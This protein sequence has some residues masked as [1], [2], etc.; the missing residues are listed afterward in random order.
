MLVMRRETQVNRR[1]DDLQPV[2]LAVDADGWGGA[3][4]LSDAL[5]V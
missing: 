2:C 5:S 3:W 1:R 4:G